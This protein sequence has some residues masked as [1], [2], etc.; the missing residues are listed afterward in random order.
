MK[1][2]DVDA[3]IKQLRSDN[4]QKQRAAAE[5]LGESGEQRA[6]KPLIKLLN[7]SLGRYQARFL[8]SAIVEALGKL[9]GKEA[10]SGLL[11]ALD[12]D[13]F[14]VKKAAADALTET[15]VEE[16]AVE[17]LEEV[18]QK[19]APKEVK[20]SVVK[21]L[22][23]KGKAK[24]I[25]PLMDI[26]SKVD[27]SDVKAE[28]IRA[29]GETKRNEAVTPLMVFYTE[30]AD[31]KLQID[32]I[33]ALANIGTIGSIEFLIKALEEQN[34]QIRSCAAL[35]LGEIRTEIAELPLKNLL[36]DS[37]EMVR[38]SAA[39]ALGLIVFIPR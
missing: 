38:K 25:R 22:G 24:S 3:L 16:S 1:K 32:I 17:K 29:L 28:A 35:A 13:Y 9:G 18:A 37:S 15:A 23:K 33:N 2:H 4:I 34:P 5:Q 14:F 39:K 10:G 21:A 6:V 19:P 36:T 31:A 26:I 27:D 20:K 30:E 8:T 12:S 11:K 7:R